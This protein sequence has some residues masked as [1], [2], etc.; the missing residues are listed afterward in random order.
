MCEVGSLFHG[1]HA[2]ALRF[3]SLARWGSWFPRRMKIHAK[4]SYKYATL[5]YVKSL[6]PNASWSLPSD[7]TGMEARELWTLQLGHS[8]GGRIACRNAGVGDHR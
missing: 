7:P 6:Q 4:E 5:H 2:K 8:A 1:L 3:G